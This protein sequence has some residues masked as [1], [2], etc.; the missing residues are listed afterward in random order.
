MSSFSRWSKLLTLAAVVGVV[1][2]MGCAP[3]DTASG[4]EAD[5]VSRV[6]EGS[7]V[8]DGQELFGHYYQPEPFPRP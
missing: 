4:G 6:Q 3:Q 5:A 1:S 7:L 8:H 2:I